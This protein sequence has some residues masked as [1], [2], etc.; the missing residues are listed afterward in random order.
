MAIEEIIESATGSGLRGIEPDFAFLESF[1][2]WIAETTAAGRVPCGS[3]KDQPESAGDTN[4]HRKQR[5]VSAML[6]MI[7]VSEEEAGH[8]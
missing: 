8:E 2:L 1:A 5:P 7:Q 6:F 3:A 4:V